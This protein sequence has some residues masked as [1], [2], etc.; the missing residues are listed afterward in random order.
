MQL[1]IT[2][3]CSIIAHCT[4]QLH[5]AVSLNTVASLHFAVSHQAALSGDAAKL[6][7]LL[8]KTQE[9]YDE[10]EA[11]ADAEH[12]ERSKIRADGGK[13]KS[14]SFCLYA[15]IAPS[16]KEGCCTCLKFT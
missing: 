8:S 14:N 5:F 4:V 11:N 7:S 3:I 13:M 10:D 6:Q 15:V 1:F 2:A 16:I 12:A 9:E